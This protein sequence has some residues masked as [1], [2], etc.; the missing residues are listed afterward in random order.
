MKKDPVE[1]W[2]DLSFKEQNILICKWI[3]KARTPQTITESEI[4]FLS[5]KENK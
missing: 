5:L 1:W 2:N 4:S 3:S